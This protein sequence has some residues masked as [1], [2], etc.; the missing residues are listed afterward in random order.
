MRPVPGSGTAWAGLRI[1]LLG[2]SF[3]PAHA[4][5]RHISLQALKR[6][7]L[8]AVWWLVSPQN[9]L[10]PRAGMAPLARRLAHARQMAAH[11]RIHVTALETRLGT[12]YTIDQ[13]AALAAR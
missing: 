12:A 4:G 11:P 5:H 10:K 2:R 3:N 9:P 1:G 7:R 13:V 8:D 6:L